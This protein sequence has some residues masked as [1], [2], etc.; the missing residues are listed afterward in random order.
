[1]TTTYTKQAVHMLKLT[2]NTA[3]LRIFDEP[4][5]AATVSLVTTI[6]TLVILTT[7]VTI[8]RIRALA[9]ITS[10]SGRTFRVPLTSWT[11][12]ELVF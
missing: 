10:L 9:R 4:S 12:Q 11:I 2:G 7:R 6:T 3:T 1:M 8:A 5:L